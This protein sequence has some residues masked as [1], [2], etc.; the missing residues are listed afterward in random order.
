MM[1]TS[2]PI[3]NRVSLVIIQSDGTSDTSTGVK[4]AELKESIKDGTIF[5]NIESLELAN[6]ILHVIRGDNAEEIDVI[7]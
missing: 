6:V 3:N 2:S 4:L 1:Q 7:V 5:S